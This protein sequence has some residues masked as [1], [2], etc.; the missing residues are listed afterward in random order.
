MLVFLIIMFGLGLVYYRGL[1]ANINAV[2]TQADNT[3][4]VLQLRGVGYA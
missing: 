2:G 4:R 3:L 1:V